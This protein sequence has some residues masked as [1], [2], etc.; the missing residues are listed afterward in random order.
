VEE[1]AKVWDVIC[2]GS[3]I[4]SLAFGAQMARRHPGRKVLILE[5]HSVPGG[6][7]STFAR[8]K[9][10]FDCSLHKLSG[11]E[12]GGNLGRIFR[13]LGLND[14]LQVT[15]SEAHFDAYHG[16]ELLP[17]SSDSYAALKARLFDR[18]PHERAGLARIA[19]RTTLATAINFH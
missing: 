5:K 11:L 15:R 7:A 8:R 1:P 2:I 17:L 13:D 16:G 14:E 3:G 10:R 18:F 6:Y 12:N 4:T 9:T 19:H